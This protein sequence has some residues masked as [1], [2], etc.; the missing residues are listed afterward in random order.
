MVKRTHVFV[1]G[2]SLHSLLGF[3]FIFILVVHTSG[4]FI[5]GQLRPRAVRLAGVQ[6]LIDSSSV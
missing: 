5:A 4:H 1:M 6:G 2:R 3:G